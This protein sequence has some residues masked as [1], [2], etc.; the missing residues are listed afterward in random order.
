MSYWHEICLAIYGGLISLKG[1]I[2][3]AQSTWQPP[4][5]ALYNH[6]PSQTQAGLSH[7]QRQL[8]WLTAI[9]LSW[10]VGLG[11]VKFCLILYKLAQQVF[12]AL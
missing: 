9:T 8:V 7:K 3:M 11:A 2:T 4:N 10:L 6:Q 12:L 5:L 1:K